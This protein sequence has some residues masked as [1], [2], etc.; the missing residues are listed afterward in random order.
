MW[1]AVDSNPHFKKLLAALRK[2]AGHRGLENPEL[3]AKRAAK[4][5]ERE[6]DWRRTTLIRNQRY[7]NF[8]DPWR[9]EAAKPD[10]RWA[11]FLVRLETNRQSIGR[12]RGDKSLTREEA[13]N[14]ATAANFEGLTPVERRAVELLRRGNIEASVKTGR[15]K[16]KK[17]SI[18]ERA[19]RFVERINSTW[20]PNKPKKGRTTAETIPKTIRMSI[21]DAI[22]IAVPVIEEFSVSRFPITGTAPRS[23]RPC[24]TRFIFSFGR[25]QTKLHGKQ[26]SS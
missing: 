26:R 19:I 13:L 18:E 15:R 8:T 16:A 7:A 1:P 12:R 20:F 23:Y 5:L 14:D 24:L 21:T 3:E 11:C 10:E 25:L 9:R 6:I 2:I 17:N 22:S 4:R